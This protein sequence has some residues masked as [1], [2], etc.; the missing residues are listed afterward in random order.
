MK[1]TIYEFHGERVK[2]TGRCGWIK[3]VIKIHHSG[4]LTSTDIDHILDLWYEDLEY[5]RQVNPIHAAVTVK[6]DTSE[7]LGE[8][9]SNKFDYEVEK[10]IDGEWDLRNHSKKSLT[11][12]FEKDWW[13]GEE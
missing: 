7:A 2:P 13:D 1:T 9:Y 4:R 8:K 6:I 5:V 10:D 11:P 3:D 12:L